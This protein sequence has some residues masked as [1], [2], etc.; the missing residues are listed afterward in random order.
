[1]QKRKRGAV[2]STLTFA[3]HL[4]LLFLNRS[5]CGWMDWDKVRMRRVRGGRQRG[6]V[7]GA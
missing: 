1:M 6:R 3:L 5:V 4:L 2:M 7:G